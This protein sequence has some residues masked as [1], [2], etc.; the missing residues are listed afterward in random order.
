MKYNI[1]KI[2]KRRS[3]TAKEIA[4]LFGLHPRTVQQWVS[5]DTLKPIDGSFNPYLIYGEDLAV[6]LAQKKAKHK[7]TLQEDEFY[8]LRCRQPRRSLPEN[9]TTTETDTKVGKEKYKLTKSGV[10]AVCGT[11]LYRFATYKKAVQLKIN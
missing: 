3:Y 7:C 6:F 1:R 2:K 5:R 11:K 8:C 10:C 4:G 9:I